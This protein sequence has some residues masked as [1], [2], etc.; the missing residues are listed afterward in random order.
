MKLE[1]SDF[2]SSSEHTK[3]R[4]TNEPTPTPTPTKRSLN[5]KSLALSNSLKAVYINLRK[6]SFL[7]SLIEANG[8]HLYNGEV[9]SNEREG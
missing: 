5:S 9:R 2:I 3:M 1:H 7:T 8:E 6:F 4:K